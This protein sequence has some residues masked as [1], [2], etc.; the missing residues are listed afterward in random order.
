MHLDF[1]M[2]REVHSSSIIFGLLAVCGIELLFN[3]MLKKQG[4]G[5]SRITDQISYARFVTYTPAESR[6]MFD[7]FSLIDLIR[8]YWDS[9]VP[10]SK[11]ATLGI[12]SSRLLINRNPY[13]MGPY[14]HPPPPRTWVDDLP[15][16]MAYGNLEVSHSCSEGWHDGAKQESCKA[17][18]DPLFLSY[19]PEI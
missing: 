12:N 4:N 13:F 19:T 9:F 11:V 2:H 14:F 7:W 16:P 15:I 8:I 17:C 10:C 6:E 18:K 5:G 3:P 1:W